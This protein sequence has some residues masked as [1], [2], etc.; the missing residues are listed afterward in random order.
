MTLEQAK[1]LRDS[2]TKLFEDG[3]F[4][5]GRK[6]MEAHGDLPLVVRL[7]CEGNLRFY[8]RNLQ[9]AIDKYEAAI[10]VNPE[11]LI[12]RYQYLVGTQD[13]KR[14]DL[15]SAFKRYQAAIEIEPTFVDSYVE[16]GGC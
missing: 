4:D 13:E 10:R 1:P 6:K 16:L 9:G 12:A 14:N 7:E 2:L 5:E 3:A 11:Y 15:V 8:M